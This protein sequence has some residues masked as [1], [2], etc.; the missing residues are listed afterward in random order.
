MRVRRAVIDAIVEQARRERPLE[1]CGLLI[2]TGDEVIQ[3][4]A[5]RNARA[6]AVAYLVDPR[7]H[8]DAIRDARAKGLSVVG[9]YH[10]HPR[11]PAQPSE[12]D[13]REANDPDFIHVIVSL[14]NEEP[15]VAAFR[16]NDGQAI[17]LPL[18]IVD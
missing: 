8:F 2:G 5:A 12:T 10:S 15:Q 9:A 6:S 1:C 17:G 4:R 3:S 14:A 16:M 11:S 7:D 13:I 18:A